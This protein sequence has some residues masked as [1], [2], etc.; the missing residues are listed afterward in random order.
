MYMTSWGRLRELD[1]FILLEW[2]LKGGPAEVYSFWNRITKI[3]ELFLVLRND[4]ARGKSHV[5]SLEGSDWTLGKSLGEWHGT[6]MVSQRPCDLHP[7]RFSR[8]S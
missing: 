3:M 6:G 1:L 4:T 7:W 2:L 5:N 8:L